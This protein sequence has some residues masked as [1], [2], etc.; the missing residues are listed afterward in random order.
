VIKEKDP[1][2]TTA[3][4]RV[5]N[6]RL[7]LAGLFI[8]VGID[9]IGSWIL[10]HR[11]ASTPIAT[12]GLWALGL[13]LFL[14]YW[15]RADSIIRGFRGS[16]EFE[17]YLFFAYPIVLIYYFWKTRRWR[18]ILPW[19]GLICLTAAPNFVFEIRRVTMR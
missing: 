1:I 13:R 10:A 7:Y 19:L 9:S 6:A 14:V 12:T 3:R 18:G 16:Y 8:L 17:A 11:V 4:D 15:V 2:E 5:W